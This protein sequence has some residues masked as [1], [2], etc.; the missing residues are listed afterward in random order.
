MNNVDREMA[1][2]S[3]VP[4]AV[5]RN[6]GRRGVRARARQNRI[7]DRRVAGT[8]RQPSGGGTTNS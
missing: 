3:G 7:A 2:A 1:Y 5:F 4:E 6:R 8:Y